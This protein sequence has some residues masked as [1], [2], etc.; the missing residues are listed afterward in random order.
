MLSS[1]PPRRRAPLGVLLA[2]VCVLAQLG[3]ALHLGLVRHVRCA[4]HGELMHADMHEDSHAHGE[5]TAAVL[6]AVEVATQA[7]VFDTGAPG[8]TP[9]H[10]H[11]Q[12]QALAGHSTEP[13][14]PSV[15]VAAPPV[16]VS[17]PALVAQT[18]AVVVALY[19]LAPKASPPTA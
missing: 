3:A 13:T 18:P 16:T 12:C 7:V 2:L 5:A 9:E 11:D 10:T 15:L 6:A 19:R 17:P 8:A 1:V 4:A 14:A